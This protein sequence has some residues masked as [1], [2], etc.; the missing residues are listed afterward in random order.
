M[1]RLTRRPP[2]LTPAG[3]TFVELLISVALLAVVG[4]VVVNITLGQ[5]RLY[6]RLQAQTAAR[7]E[8]RSA[9]ALVPVDLRGIAPAAGDLEDFAEQFVEFR[10][11]I[12]TGIICAHSAAPALDLPPTHQRRNVL[13]TWSTPPRA[14][15]TAWVFLE[16][17][18]DGAGDDR[19]DP[20]RIVEVTTTSAACAGTPF[21][22]PVADAG[23][24]GTRLTVDQPLPDTGLIGAPVRITRST[25]YGLERQPSGR[26][27]LS[28]REYADG[29]WQASAAV[30][31]PFAAPVR[32]GVAGVRFAY[33]DSIGA[34]IT[35]PALA[36]RVARIDLAIATDATGRGLSSGAPIPTDSIAFRMA[37]RNRQ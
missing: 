16:G 33:F 35:D 8:L 30:S 28:R 3:F 4:T 25:R 26:W 12:G 14:G 10:A 20:R 17:P 31:G 37:L 27:Y 21:L 15:D 5:E 24:P 36:H 19:W 29:S 9:L 11:P 22:D 7:H 2:R 34:P 32:N 1:S 18:S 13:T 6:Q 23:R